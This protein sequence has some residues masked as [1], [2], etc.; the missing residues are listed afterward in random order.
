MGILKKS[1]KRKG[2]RGGM[3]KQTKKAVRRAAVHCNNITEQSLERNRKE[4]RV[5]G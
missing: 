2:L 5:S 1:R 3:E 4:N